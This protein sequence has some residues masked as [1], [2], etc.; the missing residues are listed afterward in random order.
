MFDSRETEQHLTDLEASASW[1]SI[2]GLPFESFMTLSMG[3][4][5]EG[6]VLRVS[7]RGRKSLE[8]RR[9]ERLTVCQKCPG[10]VV[11]NVGS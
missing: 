4:K 8:K 9:E 11:L 7:E 1:K 5:I 10:R 6:S 3:A 2:A